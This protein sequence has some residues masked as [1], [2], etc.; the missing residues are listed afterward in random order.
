[1]LSSLTFS[2]ALPDF[3]TLGLL[4]VPFRALIECVMFIFLLT[5]QNP[6]HFALGVIRV[7]PF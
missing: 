6:L 4:L 3:A 1:M 5:I 2:I 7:I